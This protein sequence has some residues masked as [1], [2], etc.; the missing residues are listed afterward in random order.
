M[1]FS[2]IQHSSLNEC[3]H[4]DT[5]LLPPIESHQA[6]A[7]V[8][9]VSATEKPKILACL[10]AVCKTAG[11]KPSTKILK[12]VLYRDYDLLVCSTLQVPVHP[13]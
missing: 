3:H 2:L 8:Q 12:V 7:P 13:E 5:I 6:S 1:K 11:T 9:K 4:I 10:V